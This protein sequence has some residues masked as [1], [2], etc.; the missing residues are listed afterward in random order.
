MT[1][2]VTLALLLALVLAGCSTTPTPAPSPENGALPHDVKPASAR[3]ASEVAAFTEGVTAS[4]AFGGGYSAFARWNRVAAKDIPRQLTP[5]DTLSRGLLV[6]LVA[7]RDSTI[8]LAAH[9]VA[10][11][12]MLFQNGLR[13]SATTEQ[14]MSLD[15]GTFKQYATK[16]ALHPYPGLSLAET[17]T[18]GDGLALVTVGPR[19][20]S[21]ST[22][23]TVVEWVATPWRFSVELDRV[24]VAG[25]LRV[26]RSVGR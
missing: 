7:S 16:T 4:G 3:E 6:A 11:A 26:A 20:P 25:A 13:V 24:D 14:H 18:V 21:D 1:K 5:T 10:V 12:R 2:R 9:P 17:A 19:S 8:S 23:A 15:L 22:T